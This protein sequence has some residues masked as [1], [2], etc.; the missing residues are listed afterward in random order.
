MSRAVPKLSDIKHEEQLAPRKTKKVLKPILSIYAFINSQRFMFLSTIFTVKPRK[1]RIQW[2]MFFNQTWIAG[3]PPM[4]GLQHSPRT[5]SNLMLGRGAAIL[6]KARGFSRLG[7]DLHVQLWPLLPNC[8]PSCCLEMHIQRVPVYKNKRRMSER[9]RS[10]II[11]FKM[12]LSIAD[13]HIRRT[14]IG[15]D[16]AWKSTCTIDL[17]ACTHAWLCV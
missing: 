10:I 7:S 9:N 14:C 13:G 15:Q 17:H 12:Q 4:H 11:L 3:L 1:K 8:K 6:T 16:T 5:P 2:K